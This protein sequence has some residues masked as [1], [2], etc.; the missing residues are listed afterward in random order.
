M[1]WSFIESKVSE[2]SVSDEDRLKLCLSD[3]NLLK[4]CKVGIFLQEIYNSSRD[5]EWALFKVNNANLCL[6]ISKT[7]YS[8]KFI[9]S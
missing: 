4:L 9:I 8:R 3:E 5:I 7:N 2:F 6:I 1:F